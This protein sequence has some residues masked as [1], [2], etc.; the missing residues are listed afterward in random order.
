MEKCISDEEPLVSFIIPV[1]N[2]EKYIGR[3]IESVLNQTYQNIEVILVDDGS[4]DN[5]REICQEYCN[6]DVR[7][8]FFS[9]K[10]EGSSLTRNFGIEHASGEYLT[11]VDSDD[12]IHP[13]YTRILLD[14]IRN[15][16]VKMVQ[17]D[18][19]EGGKSEFKKPLP[20][21]IP[22]EIFADST[23]FGDRKVKISVCGK[24]YKKELFESIRF[25]AVQKYDDEFVTYKVLYEA[26]QIAVVRMCLYY[27]FYNPNSQMRKKTDYY[28]LDFVRAY[29]ERICFFAEHGDKKASDFS[30]KELAIRLMLVFIQCL[31]NR[32]NKNDKKEI[33]D[34]FQKV[35]QSIENRKTLAFKEKMILAIFRAF[36]Y[37]VS[38]MVNCFR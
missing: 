12:F 15:Y 29:E 2:V 8:R 24:L 17:C 10:N 3:C 23:M 35:Y 28:E 36:P 4:C 30:K 20:K 21:K 16:D 31:K 9:R 27:Y 33:L 19:E 25:P 26:A 37:G 34:M 7:I 11:F 14:V 1:Y 18:F 13:E 5:S 32:E 6:R 22:V 38:Y